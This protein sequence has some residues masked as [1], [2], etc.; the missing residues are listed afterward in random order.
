ME[1]L[2]SEDDNHICIRC[3]QTINGLDNYIRH[4]K[5]QKCKLMTA[6]NFFNSLQ[7]Q[8]IHKNFQNNYQKLNEEDNDDEY[9]SR[10]VENTNHSFNNS[11]EDESEDEIDIYRPPND[12]TGGKW[13]PGCAPHLITTNANN[14]LN[15]DLSDYSS[16]NSQQFIAINK[17]KNRNSD[18]SIKKVKENDSSN[19][20]RTHSLFNFKSINSSNDSN[21]DLDIS[22]PKRRLNTIESHYEYENNNISEELSFNNERNDLMNV[23]NQNDLKCN[24]C[25]FSA[26]N[27]S[28]LLKHYLNTKTHANN[29]IIISNELNLMKKLSFVCEICSFYTNE[30]NNYF[31]HLT[32]SLHIENVRFNTTLFRC[33]ICHQICDNIEK[34]IEHLKSK[35]SIHAN[36]FGPI[37]VCKISVERNNNQ[38]IAKEFDSFTCDLCNE[39]FKFK[40]HLKKHTISQHIRKVAFPDLIK[41]NFIGINAKYSCFKCD[42][43]TDCE[44]THLLHSVN[45]ELPVHLKNGDNRTNDLLSVKRNND[46]YKC[47]LC[48]NH[49]IC[50][51]LKK[52][53]NTHIE[54][55]PYDCVQCDKKFAKISYLKNHEKSHNGIRDQICEICGKSFVLTKLLKRHLK[56]HDNRRE[57]TL[58]CDVCGAKFY[59]KYIL[60]SHMKRHLPKNERQYKCTFEGCGYAFVQKNELLEHERVHWDPEDKPY[61]CDRCPYKTKSIFTFRKHYRQ[62]TGDKP[63]KCQFCD[64]RTAL[65]SNLCRHSR[66]HTGV[67]PYKCP[68]CSY[69]CNTHENVRKHILKTKKHKGLSVYVCNHCDH[70]TNVFNEYRKHIEESHSDLYKDSQINCLVS[71]LFQT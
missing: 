6:D 14:H 22:G 4:R 35:Q 31:W 39:T 5:T 38:L 40:T 45:H 59:S 47:P 2:T 27:M 34:L 65:S 10:S 58:E 19:G 24:F 66:I 67:K 18:Q 30:S 32:T 55:K 70:K 44:T 12:F 28:I 17:P 36:S 69:R 7:L 63:F 54:N 16:D 33:Q 1:S 23:Q 13:K 60:M 8:Q 49:Y 46:K 42:F 21:I 68:Y 62:H 25:N 48:D 26:N 53:I 51:E 37:I 41:S 50:R 20:K 52:H 11:D 71:N 29:E 43:K 57:R 64:Y 9:D 56:I 61:L 3:K 15:S